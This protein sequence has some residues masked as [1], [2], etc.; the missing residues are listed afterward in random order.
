MI[1]E[2]AT[3]VLQVIAPVSI[4]DDT[5]WVSD[6]I[7]TAGWEYCTI[8]CNLGVTDIAVALL[9]VQESDV[10]GTGFADVTGLVFGTSTGIDGSVSALPSAADDGKIFIFDIDC[11]SRERYLDL[12]ATAGDGALG[13]F[14]SAIAILSRGKQAPVTA[15]DRGASQILRVA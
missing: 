12:V 3:K 14:L 7:D 13:T 8:I 5:A 6:E 1:A 9:K 2:Q 15:A 10:T 4:K 11:R